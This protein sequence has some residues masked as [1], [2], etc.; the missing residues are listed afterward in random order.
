VVKASGQQAALRRLSF[1]GL[2]ANSSKEIRLRNEPR[3]GSSFRP[4]G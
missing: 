1:F 2:M 3:F 4:H